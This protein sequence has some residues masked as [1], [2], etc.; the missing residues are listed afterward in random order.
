MQERT[1]DS[2]RAEAERLKVW[3]QSAI[4]EHVLWLEWADAK[5][6]GKAHPGDSLFDS[7]VSYVAGLESRV[8]SLREGLESIGSLRRINRVEDVSLECDLCL[9]RDDEEQDRAYQ[10][11]R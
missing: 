2:L 4:V 8:A 6:D 11:K 9:D 10:C 7:M 5:L 1:T 3:K